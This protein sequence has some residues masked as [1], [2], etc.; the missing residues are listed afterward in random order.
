MMSKKTYLNFA[1][2]METPKNYYTQWNMKISADDGWTA[3]ES[4]STV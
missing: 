3:T 4:S 2:V 1:V